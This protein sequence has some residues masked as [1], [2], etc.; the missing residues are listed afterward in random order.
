[1]NTQRLLIHINEFVEKMVRRRHEVL[2]E[3]KRLVDEFYAAKLDSRYK[4]SSFI[5]NTQRDAIRDMIHAIRDIVK[6]STKI[7]LPLRGK[8]PREIF[9]KLVSMFQDFKEI[10]NHLNGISDIL[11]SEIE[12]LKN[13]AGNN[14]FTKQWEIEVEHID[15]INSLVNKTVHNI[16]DVDK[17]MTKLGLVHSHDQRR[18]IISTINGYKGHVFL[19]LAACIMFFTLVSGCSKESIE[20][21][22]F[23][24]KMKNNIPRHRVNIMLEEAKELKRYNKHHK[25]KEI[26][27]KAL[28]LANQER[29]EDLAQIAKE[30]VKDA[31]TR[32]DLVRLQIYMTEIQG[33][34][35]RLKN[36]A[37]AY[38]AQK[39][40]M[41][42][43]W[44]DIKRGKQLDKELIELEKQ[45]KGMISSIDKILDKHKHKYIGVIPFGHDQFF[46]GYANK[47]DREVR[48]INKIQRALRVN[49]K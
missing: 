33:K 30:G 38:K 19:K 1:M 15:R 12:Y 13:T 10:Y 44:L 14:L 41:N 23:H 25:A 39:R 35:K 22:N 9:K 7:L 4:L 21:I 29:I 43:N 32:Y 8:L 40:D 45:I 26:Y 16:N 47:R 3:K 20:D 24:E 34:V 36:V 42:G 46:Q 2:G 49:P 27:E 5:D 48:E 31:D 17:L 6:Y 37:G 28:G 11:R 18:G